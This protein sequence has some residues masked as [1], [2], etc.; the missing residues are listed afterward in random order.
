MSEFPLDCYFEN[1]NFLMTRSGSNEL[2]VIHKSPHNSKCKRWSRCKRERV[3]VQSKED[4][5][6]EIKVV[7]QFLLTYNPKF[8]K[9]SNETYRSYSD[10]NINE[11]YEETSEA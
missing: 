3:V 10:F 5:S 9:I 8:S 7:P 1:G 11:I 2:T 4:D 6:G